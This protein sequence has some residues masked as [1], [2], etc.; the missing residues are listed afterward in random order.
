MTDPIRTAAQALL[1]AFEA[2]EKLLVAYR[3]RVGG[4]TPGKAIDTLTKVKAQLPEIRSALAA[5]Q[6]T[7]DDRRAKPLA[8]AKFDHRSR[9]P[10]RPEYVV[11]YV[12][13]GQ[14]NLHIDGE[15]AV[16]RRTDG[17]TN[18]DVL[19]E[20]PTDWCLA[21]ASHGYSA[22]LIPVPPGTRVRVVRATD[23]PALMDPCTGG[24]TP[25]EFVP[26]VEDAESAAPDPRWCN[27]CGEAR[28]ATDQEEP[29]PH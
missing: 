13:Q 16:Y 1:D 8:Y 5:P 23:Q 10:D 24:G 3:Y 25:H 11:L 27:V 22:V 19:W 21:T 28:R 26:G 6:H 4:R 12:G 15:Y 7:N 17:P 18:D 20:G 9:P 14:E 29:W 2:H